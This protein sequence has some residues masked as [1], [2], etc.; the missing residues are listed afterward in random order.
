MKKYR[1]TL[2]EQE[3]STLET[4]VRKGG[5]KS[6]KVLNALVLLNCD[7]GAFQKHRMRNEDVAAVLRVS[8]RKIDRLKRRYVEEGMDIALQGRKTRRIYERKADS[9]FEARLLALSLTRPP[10]G[11]PRWSLRRLADRAVELH[12]VDSISYE[13]IRR[14]LK[15]RVKPP[16]HTRS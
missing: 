13:T 10:E 16:L 3:R 11:V 6:R 8:V 1:V 7:E 9:D 2:S 4:V 5:H 15:K 12:Y 14:V